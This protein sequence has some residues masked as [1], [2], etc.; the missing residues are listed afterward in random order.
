MPAAQNDDTRSRR[1]G[2]DRRTVLQGVGAGATAVAFP[3][4]MTPRKARAAI[5]L[6]VRD[7]GGPYV[8]AMTEAFYKPFNEA[9]KGDI[10]V[11]GV[12]SQ[13]EPTSM[14][15]SMVESKTYTWDIAGGFSISST[16]VLLEGPGYLEKLEIDDD[17]EV[18]EIPSRFRTP[19]LLGYEVFTCIL[20]YRTDVYPKKAP[21][22]T[23]G[24]KDLW[25]VGRIP[26]VRA[27]RKHPFYTVEQATM[28]MGVPA[29]QVYDYLR[30]NGFDPA[31]KQLD[32]IKKHV[33]IW[34]T[35]A[36]QTSQLLAT[37]EVD[38]VP[39]FNGRA[40]DAIDGGAPVAISWSQAIWTYGGMAILK[41]GPNIDACR[42]F[43]RFCA[44][45]ERQATLA[46]HIAV[47]PTNPNAF[48]YLAPERAAVL[49]TE[50]RN[51]ER[52]IEMD[53]AFWGKEKDKGTD[54]FNQWIVG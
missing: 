42:K 43:I 4:V 24:W 36:A 11:T 14:I 25:E 32:K 21:A 13:H 39:T 38:M 1:R 54:R 31:F 8:K 22:P 34:W 35:G 19:Y 27:L 47:G 33:N 18:Q 30:K 17:R 16:N 48:K 41:G 44:N 46:K 2:I 53:A 9:M 23:S 26:G 6:T 20:A 51:F 15:K 10:V 45:A 12:I 3:M 50:R 28:A 29:N 5:K 40:Q 37:G 7:P 52:S 49:G